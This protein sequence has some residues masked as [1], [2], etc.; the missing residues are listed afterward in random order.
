MIENALPG[1]ERNTGALRRVALWVIAL[2]LAY[3]AVEF[4]VARAIGSVSLFADSI[5]FLEDAAVNGLIVITLRW[6]REKQA[7]IASGLAALL[8]VPAA[9]TLW[10]A[11]EKFNQ[12][13]PPAAVPLS[14]TGLGALA[15][16]F[17]CAS[18]LARVQR[19]GGNLFRAAFLSARNDVIA[20]LAIISAGGLTLL[21]HSAW[22]DLLVGL[23]VFAI[24]FSAAREVYTSAQRERRLAP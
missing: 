15:V 6:G 13:L 16:N 2:N 20:N 14:I 22:P 19:S 5:D 17:T 10:M 23:G 3:F 12:P 9:A 1:S 24:N 18:L 7:V 21:W 11:W 4:S 8:L